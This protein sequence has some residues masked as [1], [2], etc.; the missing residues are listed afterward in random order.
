MNNRP[1]MP[2]EIE[3]T[4]PKKPDSMSDVERRIESLERDKRYGGWR[5]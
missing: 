1:R 5:G 2:V 4:M 3:T